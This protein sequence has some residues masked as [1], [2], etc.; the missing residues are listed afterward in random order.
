MNIISK[1]IDISRWQGDFDL[2]KAKAEGFEFAIIKG[3]GGDDGLYVDKRFAENYRKAKKLGIPVGV[4]WFSKALTVERA[5]EE[6]EYF[7]Q[8]CLKG[9]Q[10][11]LPVYMDIE[12]AA[13][14]DLGKRKLTDIIHAWCQHLEGKDFWVGIYSSKSYF[15]TYM[16]DSELQRYAHWV[17]AWSKSCSYSGSCF[18]MWQYGG[19]TNLIRSN[20]V[21]GV[22]CDQDYMLVDYPALIKKAGKNGFGE[23]VEESPDADTTDKVGQSE[24]YHF[25]QAYSLS[26]D[27]ELHLTTNFKVKEFAC[28]DGSDPIFI[29]PNLPRWCQAARDKF[30]YAFSPNS[31]YRT[32]SHNAKPD[33]GGSSRS[34]HI[35]GMAVDIPAK[36]NTTPQ[37][38]YDFFDELLGNSG[39]LGIYSWGV[40]VAVCETKKRFKA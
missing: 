35:Y 27:G 31:A 40:H 32:V 5:V 15:S 26:A 25:V 3:G 29:H 13:Q 1:G 24:N 20:K 28:K 10:F 33:V 22:V 9:R 12:N 39:E 4:Y 38:L 30:G 18:G 34:Y 23:T 6:A 8:N 2:E 37:M 14:L 19:E 11:E 21:A 7:Y 17:A 16:I 36:G